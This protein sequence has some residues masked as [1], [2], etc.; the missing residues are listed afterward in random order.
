M[1]VL[2]IEIPKELARGN[3]DVCELLQDPTV[4]ARLIEATTGTVLADAA[5]P[6]TSVYFVHSG[7]VRIYQ[8]G[9]E[10]S[11]RLLEI[12]GPGDW[13][14]VPALAGAPV[15]GSRA[16]AVSAVAVSRV[17]EEDWHA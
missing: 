17:R 15:Y 8:S 11:A 13:F 3:A 1:P 12:L 14:G 9:P 5:D 10:N 4:E 7:Q 6:A 16:V 2:G